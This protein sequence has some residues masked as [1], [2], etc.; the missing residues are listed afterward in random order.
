MEFCLNKNTYTYKKNTYCQTVEEQL[1]STITLGETAA[2][3][4]KIMKAT[5]EVTIGSENLSGQTLSLEGMACVHVIYLTDSGCICGHTEYFPFAKSIEFDDSYDNSHVDV[6]ACCNFINARVLSSRK[7]E[8]SGTATINIRVNSIVRAELI[9]DCDSKKLQ[10]KKNNM[11]ASVFVGRTDRNII[12]EE[13]LQVSDKPLFS[14]LKTDVVPK[15]T[16]CK[17]LSGKIMVKGEVTLKI[18]GADEEGCLKDFST[19]I[20]FSQMLETDD[21][22]DGCSCNATVRLCGSHFKPRTGSDGSFSSVI[23][24]AK[25]NI[26]AELTSQKPIDYAEDA[27]SLCSNVEI[28]KQHVDI[29]SNMTELCDAFSISRE[30]SF[31]EGDLRSIKCIWAEIG[32]INCSCS[33]GHISIIGTIKVCILGCNSDQ[34]PIYHERPVD[35]EYN[36]DLASGGTVVCE[37]TVRIENCSYSFLGDDCIEVIINL[38]ACGCAYENSS[39]DII[40]NIVSVDDLLV[41]RDTAFIVYFAQKGEEIWDIAKKYHGTVE[42]ICAVNSVENKVLN[43]ATKLIIPL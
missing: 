6:S 33:G 32:K 26:C 9:S 30:L 14:C 7:I 31:S 1:E 34:L 2:N 8:I 21:L 20:P 24:T 12:V 17:I 22:D 3:I 18:L 13:E 5:C 36:T 35:L 43:K 38:N 16:E 40:T 28:S 4:E 23:F 41:D 15:V 39:A 10:L 11:I 27:Y 37:P 19:V 29:C 42:E 25:L